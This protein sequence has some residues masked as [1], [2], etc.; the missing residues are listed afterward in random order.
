MTCPLNE[1]LSLAG[2]PLAERSGTTAVVRALQDA[3]QDAAKVF[4]SESG[5]LAKA[6]TAAGGKVTRAHVENG[7]AVL[8]FTAPVD[9]QEVSWE[10]EMDLPR[11]FAQKIRSKR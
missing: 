9:G 6:V 3:A 7:K 4:A 11:V 1:F 8:E 2:I 10:V 5:A